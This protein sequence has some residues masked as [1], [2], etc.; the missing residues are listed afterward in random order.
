LNSTCTIILKAAYH[1]GPLL[2]TQAEFPLDCEH[3]L[4]DAPRGAFNPSS[5]CEF[6]MELL[7]RIPRASTIRMRFVDGDLLGDFAIELLGKGFFDPARI[8]V[9]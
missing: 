9:E 2:K 7:A 5:L 3:Y 4:L 1:F 6:L 8:A